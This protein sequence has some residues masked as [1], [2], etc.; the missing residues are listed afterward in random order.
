MRQRDLYWFGP[1]RSNTLRPVLSCRVPVLGLFVVGVTNWSGEGVQPKSISTSVQFVNPCDSCPPLPFIDE[2][3]E[4]KKGNKGRVQSLGC[5]LERHCPSGRIEEEP[6][7]VVIEVAAWP[8]VAV[9][10]R[11][12]SASSE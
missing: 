4:G 6:R 8:G 5:P 10:F 7:Y 11:T 9:H 12:P 1:P 3:G 2:R